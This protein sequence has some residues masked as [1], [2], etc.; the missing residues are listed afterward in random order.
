MV[1]GVNGDGSREIVARYAQQHPLLKPATED[2]Q[3]QAVMEKLLGSKV[4]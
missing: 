4:C 3:E 1:N 2:Q